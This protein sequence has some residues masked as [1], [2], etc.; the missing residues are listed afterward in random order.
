MKINPKKK[1]KKKN[2]YEN[3]EEKKMN[4]TQRAE[5]NEIHSLREI[6]IESINNWLRLLDMSLL[7]EHEFVQK[8][9][10]LLWNM[11]SSIGI[12]KMPG[13]KNATRI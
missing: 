9:M 13:D 7:T 12:T 6:E 2:I 4:E 5:F 3:K 10:E 1:F 11:N 8:V